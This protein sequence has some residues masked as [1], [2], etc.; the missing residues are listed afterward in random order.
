MAQLAVDDVAEG[1]SGGRVRRQAKKLGQLAQLV[2]HPVEP[3]LVFERTALAVAE[4]LHRLCHIDKPAVL[5]GVGGSPSRSCSERATCA[6]LRR[7]MT[8]FGATPSS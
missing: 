7:H 3:R 2:A 4:V 6:G 1:G 8:I 5:A